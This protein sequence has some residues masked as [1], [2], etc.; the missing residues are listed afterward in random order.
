MVDLFAKFATMASD[1]FL[2]RQ[3]NYH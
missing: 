2:F 1:G 3:K